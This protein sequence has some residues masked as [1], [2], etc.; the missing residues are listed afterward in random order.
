MLGDARVSQEAE[1]ESLEVC[2]SSLYEHCKAFYFEQE[3][4]SDGVC[5]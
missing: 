3:N 1:L 5:F 2:F 4:E